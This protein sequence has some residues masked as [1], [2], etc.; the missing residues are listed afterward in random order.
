MLLSIIIIGKNDKYMGDY[1][2]RLQNCLSLLGYNLDKI[3]CLNKV[4]I[5]FVDWKS[6]QKISQNITLNSQSS[7]ITKFIEIPINN[8]Y[9][10]VSAKKMYLNNKFFTTLAVNI[11]VR[12]AKGE[13][14]MLTDSDSMMTLSSLENLIKLLEN[15][16]HTIFNNN[17]TLFYIRR[18]PIP[19]SLCQRQPYYKDWEKI[20]IKLSCELSPIMMGIGCIGGFAAA[21]LMHKNLWHQLRGYDESLNRPWGWSDNDLMLRACQN[22]SWIDLHM[23]GIYAMHMEHIDDRKIQ[24]KKRDPEN[25][26]NMI[27]NYDTSI[28]DENWGLPNIKFNEA[29]CHN[30]EHNIDDVFLQ[31]KPLNGF[32]RKP[33]L[34]IK[35]NIEIIR[36]MLP[37]P[38]DRVIS[39]IEAEVVYALGT[40]VY[41][42][43]PINFMCILTCNQLYIDIVAQLQTG[44]DMYLINPFPKGN[45]DLYTYNPSTLTMGLHLSKYRGYAKIIFGHLHNIW[46]KLDNDK[47]CYNRNDIECVLLDYSELKFHV[48]DP[49]EFLQS[50]YDNI[51]DKGIIVLIKKNIQENHNKLNAWQY[52]DKNKNTSWFKKLFYKDKKNFEFLNV[53]PKNAHIHIMPSQNVIVISK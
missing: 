30:I 43:N 48:D 32:M 36:P 7:K 27:I 21:Q 18:F 50:I 52:I 29:K 8:K 11:G 45:S 4:E 34:H 13:F 25:I 1:L 39:E 14:I 49:K 24:Q 9:S 46:T 38:K 16:I 20:L 3:N 42:E 41:L 15:K 53:L 37:I 23:Y 26:N 10:D 28:N 40:F 12:R 19:W 47:M 44:I 17:Q 22:H 5:I 35:N 51:S 2:Y 33:D 31:I 6:E